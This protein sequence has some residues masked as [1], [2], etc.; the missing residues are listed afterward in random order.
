M[1]TPPATFSVVVSV[2]FRL[3]HDEISIVRHKA[4]KCVG[5]LINRLAK[6]EDVDWGSQLIA[7]IVQLGKNS[8]Y[9]IRLTFVHICESLVKQVSSKL[10]LNH[11]LDVLLEL[12]RDK[13][14]NIRVAVA[15]L[16]RTPYPKWL[17]SDS[18]VSTVL[19]QMEQLDR[20]RDV[21]WFAKASSM[22][23]RD[24]AAFCNYKSWIPR[25][26]RFGGRPRIAASEI[27]AAADVN[28]GESDLKE[29]YTHE[30]SDNPACPEAKRRTTI[31]LLL[32]G[33]A[34][35]D[36]NDP[37]QNSTVSEHN[38]PSV[39]SVP[40]NTTSTDSNSEYRGRRESAL[41]AGSEIEL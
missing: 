24:E 39:L 25:E 32:Q 16:C 41:S 34:D 9:K 7:R 13:V 35:S 38:A 33:K 1:F 31:E 18:R 37:D 14:A 5:L 6:E 27:R 20:D 4:A 8:T 22:K 15:R 19:G 10:F 12:S 30:V 26:N 17:A 36:V 28:S 29:S 40:S 23:N 21:V 3:L 2:L 11:F